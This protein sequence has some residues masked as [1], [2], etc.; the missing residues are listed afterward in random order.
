VEVKLGVNDEDK[1]ADSL[2]KLAKKIV[3]SGGSPPAFLAVICGVCN[4]SYTRP[5][6]VHVVPITSLDV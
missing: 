4:F 1:A 3:G 2:L 5:D 6:G